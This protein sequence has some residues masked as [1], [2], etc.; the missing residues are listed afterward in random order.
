MTAPAPRFA[1]DMPFGA[2]VLADGNTR[3]RLWAPD[4]TAAWIDFDDV[5]LSLIHI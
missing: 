5:R 4:A 1:H 3:F 2:T